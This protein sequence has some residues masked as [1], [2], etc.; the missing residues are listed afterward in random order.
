MGIRHT[1]EDARWSVRWGIREAAWDVEERVLWRGTDAA[2][3]AGERALAGCEPLQR[4]IQ[5]KLAWPVA[6][7]WRDGGTVMRTSMATAAIAAVAAT[8]TAG[9]V[10]LASENPSAAPQARVAEAAAAST[11]AAAPIQETLQG[12]TPDFAAGSKKAAVPAEPT[13][14]AATGKAR[15]PIAV[16]QPGAPPTQVA[17]AFAEAFV[18]YEV[19]EV[20]ESTA[21]TFAAVAE[22]PLAQSLEQDPPRL[23]A[24]TEVPEARVVNVV[25][26]E[27]DGKQV[28]ASVSLV[29]LQAASELRLTLQAYPEGWQVVGVRG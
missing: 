19:G 13:S 20:D 18:R 1:A 4:L 9:G 26:S 11:F 17:Q 15:P 29:R 5:T 6:D 16:P 8:G 24:G 23:P 27:P 2:R 21:A 14:V 12:V 3:D 22:K 10:L 25:L 7:A 28:E